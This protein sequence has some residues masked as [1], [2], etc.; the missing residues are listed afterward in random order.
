M[1]V[2]DMRKQ[3][4]GYI[5]QVVNR[6]PARLYHESAYSYTSRETNEDDIARAMLRARDDNADMVMIQEYG[7]AW[8]I[9]NVIS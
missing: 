2:H 6:F 4:L 3:P 7:I 5:Q 1:E 9:P 8:Y